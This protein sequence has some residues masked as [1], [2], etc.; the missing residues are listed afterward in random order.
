M[1][2]RINGGLSSLEEKVSIQLCQVN[3]QMQAIADKVGKKTAST[4]VGS[5]TFW[6]SRH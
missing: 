4:H 3:S 5:N 1:E 2:T 6:L